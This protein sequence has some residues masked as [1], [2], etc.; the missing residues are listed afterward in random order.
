M[1]PVVWSSAR[2]IGLVGNGTGATIPLVSRRRLAMTVIVK[3]S[4]L[5]L[6]LYFSSL[7]SVFFYGL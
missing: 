4:S 6:L 1:I 7:S 3:K 5:I 2:G